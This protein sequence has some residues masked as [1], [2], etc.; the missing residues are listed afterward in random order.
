[1]ML[2]ANRIGWMWARALLVGS[3]CRLGQAAAL[4]VGLIDG[5]RCIIELTDPL[6]LCTRRRSKHLDQI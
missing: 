4:Y 6:T 3:A 5:W 2:N 1:M